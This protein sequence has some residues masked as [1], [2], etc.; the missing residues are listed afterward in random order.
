MDR[1]SEG[2]SEVGRGPCAEHRDASLVG[3]SNPAER[4]DLIAVALCGR[5][6]E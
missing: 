2:V 1:S 6:R 5:A 3:L 4:A